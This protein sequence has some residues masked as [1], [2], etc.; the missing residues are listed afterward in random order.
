MTPRAFVN[1]ARNEIFLVVKHLVQC[2]QKWVY[3]CP[4]TG[5]WLH[6]QRKRY[7][8]SLTRQITRSNSLKKSK[9]N[10][11]HSQTKKRNYWFA[12]TLWL[13]KLEFSSSTSVKFFKQ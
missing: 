10:L 5:Y 6:E 8:S 7:Q 13:D 3:L 4:K 9:Q 2:I 11:Y 12:K 1:I